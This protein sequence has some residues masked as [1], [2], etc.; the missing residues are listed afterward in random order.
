LVAHRIRAAQR[1][2]SRHDEP[3]LALNGDLLHGEIRRLIRVARANDGGVDRKL[4]L[5]DDREDPAPWEV[6]LTLTRS[7]GGALDCALGAA[8]REAAAAA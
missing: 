4:E 1:V 3:G 2:V 7:A 6:E 8:R 5:L